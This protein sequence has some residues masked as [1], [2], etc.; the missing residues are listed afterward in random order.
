M[1][2]AKA[3]IITQL[4]KDLLSLQGFKSTLNNSD[5]NAKLGPIKNAF[6][7]KSFPL[8]AIHEFISV[9]SEDAAV[10]AGFVSGILGSLMKKGG[11]SIWI[12]S[13]KSIFLPALKS[14]GIAPDKIIFINLHKEKEILWAT[15]EALKSEGLAG[16]VA[17][18]KELDFTISRRLQLAVE[19]SQVTGF[20]L[21]HNPRNINTTACISRWKISSL[22]S[23][24]EDGMPGV[25]FPR[26][27]V[28][29]IRVRN[30]KPASWKIELVKGSFRHIYK[31]PA[32]PKI[33]KVQTG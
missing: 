12:G 22:P 7:G 17:Q 30:G 21:R 16:V 3:D 31:I 20:I 19:K 5:L 9:N 29:L 18:L 26:W 32:I 14:F 24:V 13:S 33:Q 6:P 4:K 2:T 28:E 8:A 27:N 1:I 11:V 15:E 23:E 10:T 25:G